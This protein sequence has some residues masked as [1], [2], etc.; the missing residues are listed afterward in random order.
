M[1][2]NQMLIY[3]FDC[4]F[5]PFVRHQSLIRDFK[6][7]K[8]V[9]PKGWGYKGDACI[10]DYGDK[11]GFIVEN[12]FESAMSEC[13]ALMLVDSKL[14]LDFDS[15]IRSKVAAA[16]S[17]HKIIYNVRKFDDQTNDEIKSICEKFNTKIN[18]L[19]REKEIFASENPQLFE[20]NTPVILVIG[21]SE[22]T[23]K[24]EIELSITEKFIHDNYKV[25]LIASRQRC[26]FLGAHSFPSFMFDII[27]DNDKIIYFNHLIKGIEMAE[28]PDVIVVGLPGGALPINKD[29]PNGFGILTYLVS[30]ALK[31]DYVIMSSLYMDYLGNSFTDYYNSINCMINRK[32]GF[33]IDYHNIANSIIVWNE[34]NEAKELEYMRIDSSF[35][36]KKFEK[37]YQNQ[38]FSNI[39]N[40]NS[41]DKLYESIIEKLSDYSKIE[42]V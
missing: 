1:K 8:L 25:S 23:N 6:L 24:F 29:F 35:L 15:N 31:P 11:T 21:L 20:I 28:D 38:N 16:A 13:D 10:A 40:S 33:E 26:E 9:S 27:N 17:E 7:H 42:T 2:M 30:Q 36:D 14:P 39:L 3:P 34:S 12:D 4:E 19:K 5:V 22:N 32:F 37:I 41:L 18:T